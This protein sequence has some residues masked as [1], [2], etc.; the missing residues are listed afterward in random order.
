MAF[1]RVWLD[2]LIDRTDIVQV[3]SRH[4]QLTKRG[5]RY[6]GLCPFHMEKTAS[7]S[8]NPQ[9]QM[10][11]CFGC[12]AS[13]GA[14]NFLMEIEHLEFKEA[15]TQLA[16]DAH[17]QLPENFNRE[18]GSG[19]NKAE[20][21]RIYELNREYAR[22]LHAQLWEPQNAE[23][24]SYFH[25]RALNDRTIRKFGLGASPLGGD[26]GTRAM[27]DLGFTDKELVQSGISLDRNGRLFDMFRGRAMFP[28]INA[29]G[30]VLGFGGRAL[31][32]DPRKYM[33]TG[34]TLVFNKRQE[35]F[36]ANLLKKARNLKRIILTEGYMDV[37]SL[38]QAGVEGVVATL[39]TALT[40]E[41]ARLLKRYAPEIWVSYDGDS[42]GQ[43]AILRALDIFETEHVPVRVLDFPN[44][45]DPDEYVRA[46]GAEG[47]DT[48]SP[49]SAVSY[50]MLREAE[51]HD[52]SSKEGRTEYAIACAKFLAGVTEPVE[53]ENYV[54]RLMIETGFTREVLLAQIGRTET[55][56]S[57]RQAVYR[58]AAKPLEA[59]AQ[60][61][62]IGTDAAEKQ[63]LT[64]LASGIGKQHIQVDDFLSPENRH[65]AEM[66]LSGKNAAGMLEEIED[67]NERTR[68]ARIL[69]SYP[70]ISED[71]QMQ[72]INDC[73]AVLRTKKRDKRVEQ[74]KSQISGLDGEAKQEALRRMQEMIMKDE[75]M[76]K[77]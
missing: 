34:D 37:I 29:R 62:D 67:E 35:V 64:F 68:F 12:H 52:M 30:Q 33:N 49:E 10:Y 69:D 22:Y 11:Y 71:E 60:G 2:D 66:L 32:N 21:D 59:R 28:I 77:E 27:R 58:R 19:V 51:H 43:H 24:L 45:M 20:R 7:F 75:E 17:V 70:D 14:I 31:G 13:G 8:V 5:N 61:V 53:L 42:A 40:I 63:L 39:G 50:R 15:V 48:L 1:S 9:M 44:G 47:L 46:Y 57:E 18:S 36:A 76:G 41:Q 4:V 26:T 16:D 65:F 54:Q 23:V 73:L 56:T 6:W 55:M 25:N 3:V 38:I 72:A 74:M